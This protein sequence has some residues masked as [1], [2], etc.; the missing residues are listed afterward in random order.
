[1]GDEI[2][3]NESREDIKKAIRTFNKMRLMMDCYLIALEILDH[4]LEK[5]ERKEIESS[6]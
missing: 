4:L 2:G 1:M 6:R 5:E 3:I